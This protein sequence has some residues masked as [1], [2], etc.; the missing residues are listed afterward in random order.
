M[1]I[2]EEIAESYTY[3]GV[4]SLK[5]L[6]DDIVT[7]E[8]T[9]DSYNTTLNELRLRG[10]KTAPLVEK[11]RDAKIRLSLLKA[12]YR[13]EKDKSTTNDVIINMLGLSAKDAKETESPGTAADTKEPVP[14][15]FDTAEVEVVND[16]EGTD[17]VEGEKI[18]DKE[19]IVENTGEVPEN[20]GNDITIETESVKD[21]TS[22]T[23]IEYTK[24]SN[25]DIVEEKIEE[26]QDCRTVNHEDEKIIEYN[27]VNPA[28]LTIDQENHSVTLNKML[29]STR[30]YIIPKN[31][32]N[33]EK[34]KKTVDMEKF[35]VSDNVYDVRE[36]TDEE[37]SEFYTTLSDSDAIKVVD[38]S[39]VVVTENEAPTIDCPP[40]S[41]DDYMEPVLQANTEPYDDNAP[42][43]V[44]SYNAFFPEYSKIYASLDL[45]EYTDLVN[46]DFIDAN[47]NLNKKTLEVVFK[48]NRDYGILLKLLSDEANLSGI[49]G[50]IFKKRKSIFMYVYRDTDTGSTCTKLEFTA[51]RIKELEDTTYCS[52]RIALN[53]ENVGHPFLVVFK[54]K[55]LKIT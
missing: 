49:F 20:T 48:D 40:P 32:K 37:L 3:N 30:E 42:K 17:V 47:I 31:E 33:K 8:N 41:I 26:P 27:F 45:C 14:Q 39:E 52:R 43:D 53:Q 10:K 54:Y 29:E 5:A 15:N 4:V 19:I 44:N 12:V 28:S 1:N 11:I 34:D 7:L 16:D 24:E 9:I 2:F 25:S 6:E 46:T 36:A 38:D 13:K 21:I 55:K 22:G 18:K 35:K 23:K 50:R 51:C